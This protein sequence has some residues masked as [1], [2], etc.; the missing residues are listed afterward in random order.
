MDYS[1]VIRV[2]THFSESSSIH[3]ETLFHLDQGYGLGSLTPCPI[4]ILEPEP[5]REDRE[6]PWAE[7]SQNLLQVSFGMMGMKVVMTNP[8]VFPANFHPAS[9]FTLCVSL[10]RNSMQ[11]SR[12]KTRS[13]LWFNSSPSVQ[14]RRPL[15][16][17]RRKVDHALVFHQ[18]TAPY[19]VPPAPQCHKT[20][21][22]C[23]NGQLSQSVTSMR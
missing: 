16:D 5:Y 11:I 17:G 19:D 13:Q 12:V 18:R 4:S 8:A 6:E 23:F 10:K 1:V 21:I 2:A 15:L 20:D 9:F 14:H 7:E 3:S 22:H